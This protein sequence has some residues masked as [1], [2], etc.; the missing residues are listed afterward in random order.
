MATNDSISFITSTI[1]FFFFY[2]VS[3]RTFYYYFF[4]YLTSS[5]DWFALLIKCF[6]FHLKQKDGERE[7]Y[8]F[9]RIATTIMADHVPLMRNAHCPLVVVAVNTHHKRPR[10]HPAVYIVF[11]FFVSYS[12]FFL[13]SAAY[14]FRPPPAIVQRCARSFCR[15]GRSFF[16]LFCRFLF[17]FSF[18]LGT[19][20][21]GSLKWTAIST[22]RCCR[23]C[24]WPR[25]ERSRRRTARK[26][27]G[28]FIYYI[29]HCDRVLYYLSL[30]PFRI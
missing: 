6:F 20:V 28:V 11:F 24:R 25:S 9:S 15:F 29:R 14:Y 8:N 7:R 21:P 27:P 22:L 12:Q 13:Y 23:R 1:V 18:L 17:V 16:F 5:F 4:L 2:I 3:T 10:S 26:V 30:A 19:R